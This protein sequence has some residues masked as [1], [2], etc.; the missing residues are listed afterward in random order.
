[1][2]KQMNKIFIS[3]GQSTDEEKKLGK[4]I[5]D[6][7]RELTSFEPY[8]AEFQTTLEGLSKNIFSELYE[9][10]GFITVMHRRGG[11]TGS[12]KSRASV[13]VEQEI[14]IAAFINEVLGRPIRVVAL[15]QP[16]IVLEGVRQ[17]LLLNPKEFE[18]NEEALGHLREILPSWNMGAATI[19]P[20][21]LFLRFET[22]ELT[23]ERHDYDFIV[24]V[25]NT[26]SIKIDEYH[27]DLEFPR[28]VLISDKSR[29]V[30]QNRSSDTHMFFRAPT[31]SQKKSLYPGDKEAVLR[32]NFF[33]DYKVFKNTALLD[34]PVTAVL[35]DQKDKIDT[36][37]LKLRDIQKF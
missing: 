3:C 5:Q 25:E 6:L 11:I 8:F 7:V 19:A 9:C 13:W 28:A 24:E 30:V 37:T 27:V 10:Q 33:V 26:G 29:Y 14:A 17:N 36:K 15:T 22:R 32:L 35:Y 12:K 1:L 2:Q 4:Q 34:L 21:A 31:E 16:G 23:Q 20:L 18:T